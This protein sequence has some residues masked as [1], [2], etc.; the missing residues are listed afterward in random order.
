MHRASRV[1]Q[2]CCS[3]QWGQREVV[4]EILLQCLEIF[5]PSWTPVFIAAP[6]AGHLLT[7]YAHGLPSVRTHPQ[8]DDCAVMAPQPYSLP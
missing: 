3:P 5:P 4:N 1:H 2:M 8:R 6:V 7:N